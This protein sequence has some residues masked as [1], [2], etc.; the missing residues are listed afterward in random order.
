MSSKSGRLIVALLAIVFASTSCREATSP[1]TPS[2]ISVYVALT[3]VDLPATVQLVIANGST[4]DVKPNALQVIPAT[5]G[6]NAIRIGNLAANCAADDDS[7]RYVYVPARANSPAS[8][9]VA[10]VSLVNR[11]QDQD[12]VFVRNGDLH[13]IRS[14]GT[15]LV[16]L[17][18]A[19][20]GSFYFDPEWSPDGRRI[21]FTLF[22]SNRLSVYVMN[23]DGPNVERPVVIDALYPSWSPTGSQIAFMG[24]AAI[25]IAS[26]IG[27]SVSAIDRPL[28]KDGELPSWSSQDMIA[29]VKGD[30]DLSDNLI[31]SD[32]FVMTKNGDNVRQI[33]SGG[34]TTIN[35]Y[36]VWSPNG[37]Q[38]AIVREDS[39]GCP[40]L[41]CGIAIMNGDGSELRT[42]LPG[43]LASYL[44]WSPD[45]RQI[46]FGSAHE[47]E[48]VN[49]DGSGRRVLAIGEYPS[50]RPIPGY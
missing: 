15:G 7:P 12:I 22:K 39:R 25:R 1:E 26:A 13:V 35:S 47:I 40:D 19:Q 30:Y 29:F 33:T 18:E 16:K 17:T 2:S 8:F 43:A 37:L 36:P 20:P 4:I 6:I 11:I 31:R 5:P 9:A 46:V 38:M 45:G 50:W 34:P 32:V 21:V 23:A 27:P 14:D 44:S 49:A 10:C 41:T 3:G 48:I 42:I 24:N 28:L